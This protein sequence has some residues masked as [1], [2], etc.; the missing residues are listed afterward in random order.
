MNRL[1]YLYELDSVR[2]SEAEV[3][4]GQQA[5]FRETV[6]RGNSVVLSFNQ[7]TDSYAILSLLREEGSYEALLAL[8]RLGAIK[9][10]KYGRIFSASQYIQNALQKCLG[11]ND[12]SFVFSCLP[13]KT[14]E[15]ELLQ[16]IYESLAYSNMEKLRSMLRACKQS[17]CTA[18][19]LEER[20]LLEAERERLTFIIRYV[21]LL[22]I[23]SM[24]KLANNPAR[25]TSGTSLIDCIHWFMTVYSSLP[26]REGLQPIVEQGVCY[27]KQIER[28]LTEAGQTSFLN[29]R[30]RWIE[31]LALE[32]EGLSVELKRQRFMANAILDICYNVTIENSI[33]GISTTYQLYEASMG[34]VFVEQLSRYWQLYEEK[35]HDFLLH[36]KMILHQ[37]SSSEVRWDTAVR[38]LENVYGKGVRTE[39]E[40]VTL[41]EA[42]APR[43]ESLFDE[44][45]MANELRQWQG[46]I[47]RS[48]AKRF[49]LTLGYIGLFL[50]IEMGLN[51]MDNYFSHLNIL[52]DVVY[53]VLGI[54]LFGLIGSIISQKT[55]V[56]DILECTY[57]LGVGCGDTIRL[58]K[59]QRRKE[60][61]D[62]TQSKMG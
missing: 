38:T 25:K 13:V 18:Q 51:Q 43:E 8:F 19:T 11:A 1:V 35:R 55:N 58:Y 21:Q 15:H 30:S 60:V 17:I 14:S 46:K 16:I 40:Q 41:I 10:S 53:S 12:D 48:M 5:L 54:V 3:V 24:E 45:D 9:I 42:A 57:D 28:Q 20:T 49:F 26:W 29:N 4:L 27:L 44:Q 56:P 6:L 32:A 31:A 34:T 22:L 23:I 2:N 52:P 61:N 33:C 47:A 7:L 50:L 62:A 36:S 37:A 59:A 39:E